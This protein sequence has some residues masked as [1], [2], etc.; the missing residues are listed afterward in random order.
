[1]KHKIFITFLTAMLVMLVSTG[2]VSAQLGEAESS[3]HTLA[4]GLSTSTPL[5]TAFTYQGHLS[6]GSSSA[7]GSYD[8]R[9]RLFDSSSDGVQVGD[10]LT[11]N[12]VS[13]VD[14]FFTVTLDFG[15]VFDG[16]TLYLDVGVRPAESSTYTSL[17][18]RQALTAAPYANY[19]LKTPWSGIN[20][21]PSGLDDGDDDTTY[22]AGSG[23]TLSA[24]SFSVN[25]AGSGTA[26]S[27]SRSDHDHMGQTWIND[28][29][30][31]IFGGF[32]P[33][34]STG[35]YGE[36]VVG[37]T[38]SSD[39][40]GGSFRN[41]AHLLG[42][43]GGG[44]G[45]Y[46]ESSGNAYPDIVLG[47]T[48]SDDDGTISS[49][50]AFSTSD[51]ILYANDRVH[52]HLDEANANTSIFAIKNGANDTV[53]SVN[54]SGTVTSIGAFN[55][56]GP[57]VVQ[58]S[59]ADF[60]EML[61]ADRQVEPGDVLIINK[62][63]VLALS[64][65]PYQSN[66]VGVHSTQPGYLGGGE[67][68]GQDGF[69]PL[70]VVGMVPVKVSAENGPIQPGDLLTSSVT[71]GHAMRAGVDPPIGTIIGKAMQ[72]LETGTGVIQ[73]LVVLQ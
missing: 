56:P 17:S 41:L 50:P 54:E 46:V 8:F 26:S 62:Q 37:G 25:F 42:T 71:P 34:R 66:V 67:N 19:A 70:A 36:G 40:Y 4:A 11:K 58:E 60:A 38:Y 72:A 21:V 64:T 69:V 9:F 14:G 6:D 16:S 29:G 23:L 65:Q 48:T 10:T 13:V 31:L 24:G 51:I 1:M 18:P 28:N 15:N 55:C 3:I 59:S 44:A 73:M 61:P 39:H 32:A 33:V 30:V 20:G 49:D 43:G 47:G 5:G 63:G 52:I 2:G 57:C 45:L 35:Y 7:D 12:A 53:F 27:V 22:Q 68:M